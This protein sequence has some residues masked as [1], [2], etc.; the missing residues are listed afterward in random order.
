MALAAIGAD[1]GH[2]S[3]CT[4][5]IRMDGKLDHALNISRSVTMIIIAL[6]ITL[7]SSVYNIIIIPVFA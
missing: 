6:F 7:C 4:T 5:F 1:S 2:N 3:I